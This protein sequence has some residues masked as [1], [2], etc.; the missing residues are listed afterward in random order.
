MTV[1]RRLLLPW[2][3]VWSIGVAIVPLTS[4]LVPREGSSYPVVPFVPDPAR[5]LVCIS[6]TL[7]FGLMFLGMLGLRAVN[8]RTVVIA[9]LFRPKRAVIPTMLGVAVSVVALFAIEPNAITLEPVLHVA[10]LPRMEGGT[11]IYLIQKLLEPMHLA[12]PKL[13][14][15]VIIISALP[16]VLYW[17]RRRWSRRDAA[18]YGVML[19][20]AISP[21]VTGNYVSWVLLPTLWASRRLR[22]VALALTGAAWLL[23]IGVLTPDH[24]PHGLTVMFWGTVV[25]AYGY[26]FILARTRHGGGHREGLPTALAWTAAKASGHGNVIRYDR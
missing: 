14:A 24:R 16:I 23:D 25:L 13:A 10:G 11:P 12:H 9:L 4:V 15:Q 5:L 21:F 18:L 22:G 1:T 17:M 3:V 26:F 2:W 19:L 7:A 6:W 8:V 20:L